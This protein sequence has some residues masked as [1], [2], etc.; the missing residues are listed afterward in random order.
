MK[1]VCVLLFILLLVGLTVAQ[2]E[3]TIGIGGEGDI[4]E[5]KG[6]IEDYSPL[7]ESG[8]VDYGK[9]QPFVTKAEI[10]IGAIN[11]WLN[12]NVGWMRYIFHMKP[13]VSIF[14]F[15]Y[16]Y[17]ILWFFVLLFLNAEG[18]WFFIEE[19][20][21]AKIFGASAFFVFMIVKLYYGITS[22]IHSWLSYIWFVLLDISIWA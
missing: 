9:Y 1:R 13:E 22:L 10:R 17:I 4:E 6:L 19:G 2:K 21:S 20:R 12:E 7:D 14:F 8:K 15:I 3:P 11:L 18:L 16:I 5:A